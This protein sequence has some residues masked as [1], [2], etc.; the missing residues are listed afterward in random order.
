MAQYSTD[1]NLSRRIAI[2]Q[3]S[4]NAA[5]WKDWYFAHVAIKPGSRI[6]DVGC[7]NGFMWSGRTALI[8]RSCEIELA[9]A[10][11]GM[12]EA[13]R[14]N[15]AGAGRNWH[16]RVAS[17][18]ELPYEENSFDLV[19]ANHMLYHVSDLGG[20]LAE[21]A[22][23][24]KPHGRLLASTNGVRHMQQLYGWMIQAGFPADK[25]AARTAGFR[26]ENGEA[27]LRRHFHD[28]KAYR[29]ED[30]LS[31]GAVNPVLDYAWSME[32]PRTSTE[33]ADMQRLREL[34]AAELE[35]HGII[36]IDKDSGL[37]EARRPISKADPT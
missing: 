31:V 19:M 22:R 3:F 2:H 30:S 36:R 15:L 14:R 13:A 26:L 27:M 29:H 20:A 7:G 5:S 37:F 12:L 18:E 17:V 34:V 24:V 4:V 8:D 21:L 25:L 16:F 23:V 9:D 1:D 33:E 28:V 35:R 10:S 32:L 11:A 6:L